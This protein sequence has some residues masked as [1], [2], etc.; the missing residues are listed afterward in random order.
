MFDPSAQRFPRLAVWGI[1]GLIAVL[2]PA[3]FFLGSYQYMRGVVEARTELRAREVSRLIGVNPLMWR[4]EELRLIELLERGLAEDHAEMV[5]VVTS[6][7]EVIART[8]RT[9]GAPSARHLQNIHDAGQVIGQLRTSYSLR[10]LLFRTGLVG[11]SSLGLTVLLVF[12]FRALS[13]REIHESAR[14]LR[15]SEQHYRSLYGSMKEGLAIHRMARPA[16]GAPPGLTLLDAN[17]NGLAMFELDRKAVLGGDSFTIFGPGFREHG[18]ELLGVEGREGIASFEMAGPGGQRQFLVHAFSPVP[19]QI[20]TLFED[21]TEWKRSENLRL[22]LERQVLNAQK[23]ESLGVLSGGIAH[24][25]NNLL[26]AL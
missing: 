26:A 6:D 4:F 18:D 11:L 23:L 19:G 12:V 24:D 5:E 15:E 13:L 25:F 22:T 9:P 14:A 20:A 7:G 8:G 1:A 3:I 10:P 17:P 16:P 2:T 21:I